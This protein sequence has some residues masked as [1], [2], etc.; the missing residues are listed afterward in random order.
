[1]A[2]DL[3][4][5]QHTCE[6]LLKFIL[7]DDTVTFDLE[8]MTL[9]GV[10]IYKRDKNCIQKWFFPWSEE[11]TPPPEFLRNVRETQ[12]KRNKDF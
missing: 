6:G 3:I 2:S 7:P 10:H 12:G 1:M 8:I 4:A 5:A 9:T 11:N